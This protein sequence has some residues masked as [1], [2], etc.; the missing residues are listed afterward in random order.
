MHLRAE[1]IDT[2]LIRGLENVEDASSHVEALALHQLE[3]VGDDDARIDPE[4]EDPTE[5]FTEEEDDEMNDP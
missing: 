1:R 2:P 4:E 3:V 5:V